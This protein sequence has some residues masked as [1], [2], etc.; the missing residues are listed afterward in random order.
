MKRLQIVLAAT[1][2]VAL[3]GGT[4]QLL[5]QGSGEAEVRG[6]L[7]LSLVV[8]ALVVT[9]V[10]AGRRDPSSPLPTAALVLAVV[11][12]V[13]MLRYLEPTWLA[14]VA[15]AV[16]LAGPLA[17]V[18]VLGAWP[19]APGHR[20]WRQL[21]AVAWI[22]P[23]AISVVLVLSAGARSPENWASTLTGLRHDNPLLVVD[24]PA[25]QV[26]AWAIWSAW[27]VVVAAAVVMVAVRRWR[28]GS[29]ATRR[30]VGPMV[31]AAG[32]WA[33]SVLAN[34]A[35]A[36][37]A[38][39]SVTI[40]SDVLNNL[41][42]YLPALGV[43]VLAGTLVWVEAVRPG[44][45]QAGGRHE[46]E[47]DPVID[48]GGLEQQLANALGDPTL[49]V[50]FASATGGWI[51]SDGTEQEAGGPGRQL[52]IVRRDGEPLAALDTDA[53]LAVA[54]DTI[55]VA[56]TMAALSIDNE[57]LLALAAARLEAAREA[58]AQ[59]LAAAE[60]ARVRFAADVREGPGS[61]LADAHEALADSHDSAVSLRRAQDLVR[62]AAGRVRAL[63]H[64]LVPRSLTTDGLGA[65][66]DELGGRSESGLRWTGTLDP[67]PLALAT[68]C[69]L[70]VAEAVAGG[71]PVDAALTRIDSDA[72]LAVHGGPAPSTSLEARVATL[73]GSIEAA[74]DT[75]TL[76][77]PLP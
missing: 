70:V 9:A 68:T 8:G 17:A 30:F 1:A 54:P 16:W 2:V 60:L 37:P 7:V 14:T 76:R 44:L 25:L 75:F 47:A 61:L 55:E 36:W 65:A 53:T 15:A 19:D 29:A 43:A 28:E 11:T 41:I 73:S 62:T 34:I 77:L 24:Q 35:G 3:V 42:A 74:G 64:G 39:R 40:S 52:T 18:P 49:R 6:P 32:W 46:L 71:K 33:V 12:V 20:R 50:W 5:V 58:A 51:G 56:A 31:V 67:L 57:R 10:S 72:V 59:V 48:R 38:E 13:A 4:V 22:V 27:L 21:L 45:R 66:L 23:A 69:Y 63:S 26:A